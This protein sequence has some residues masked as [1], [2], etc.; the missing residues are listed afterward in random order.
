[1]KRSVK[2]TP[3]VGAKKKPAKR[4]PAKITQMEKK[5]LQLLAQANQTRAV[6]ATGSCVYNAGS[7]TYCAEGLTKAQCDQMPNGGGIWTEG[8]HCH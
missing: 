1:M 8:G 7:G 5:L 4:K 6:A 2:K 3:K